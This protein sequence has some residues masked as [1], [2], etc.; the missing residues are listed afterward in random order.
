MA[1]VL[2]AFSS[3]KCLDMENVALPSPSH[4]F[5]STNSLTRSSFRIDSKSKQKQNLCARDSVGKPENAVTLL[6]HVRVRLFLWQSRPQLARNI[7]GCL[8]VHKWTSVPEPKSFVRVFST[9]KKRTQNRAEL[10]EIQGYVRAL[11]HGEPLKGWHTIEIWE[12]QKEPCK[13]VRMKLEVI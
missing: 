13:N 9:A 3:P 7:D 8:A 12:R 1:R 5:H 10:S 11:G 2:D 6:F 4:V